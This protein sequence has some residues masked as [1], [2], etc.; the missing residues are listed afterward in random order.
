MSEL[1]QN[2]LQIG[3]RCRA[4]DTI[5]LKDASWFQTKPDSLV[6]SDCGMTVPLGRTEYETAAAAIEI[7]R[8]Q[9]D[10]LRVAMDLAN[11]RLR[12]GRPASRQL[13]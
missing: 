1:N 2:V 3:V 13:A 6:C 4:C 8:H 5:N 7:H 10:E 11:K 9:M 12:G